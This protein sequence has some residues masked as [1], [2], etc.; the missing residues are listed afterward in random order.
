MRSRRLATKQASHRKVDLICL[1]G[2]ESF[3]KFTWGKMIDICCVES[4]IK[5]HSL[6]YWSIVVMSVVELFLSV[7][8]CVRRDFS[9]RMIRLTK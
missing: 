8:K 9:F 7:Q 1:N 5:Y 3:N 2:F 4:G 6:S